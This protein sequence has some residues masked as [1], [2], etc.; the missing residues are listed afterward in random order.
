MNQRV[1]ILTSICC[2]LALPCAAE[3]TSLAQSMTQLGVPLSEFETL[4]APFSIPDEV[5]MFSTD[6]YIASQPMWEVPRLAESISRLSAT[7][8]VM[9]LGGGYV[10]LSQENDGLFLAQESDENEP[11]YIVDVCRIIPWACKFEQ[12]SNEMAN[13]DIDALLSKQ[14]FTWQTDGTLLASDELKELSELDF[15]TVRPGLGLAVKPN[16]EPVFWGVS[17]SGGTIIWTPDN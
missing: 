10:V 9:A 16:N 3:E 13:L 6:E 12:P 14:G 7:D 15:V 5:N 2:T 11:L 17:P 8:E 1:N 4:A